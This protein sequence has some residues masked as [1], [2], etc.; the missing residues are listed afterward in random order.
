MQ[1][2]L[3]AYNANPDIDIQNGKKFR[4]FSPQEKVASEKRK[5]SDKPYFVFRDGVVIETDFWLNIQAK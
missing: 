2:I 4:N 3:D 5:E 1:K